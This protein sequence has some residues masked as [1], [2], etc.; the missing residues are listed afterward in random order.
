MDQEQLY[1]ELIAPL[2]LRALDGFKCTVIAYG[3]TG[4][5]KTYTMQGDESNDLKSTAAG[6]I[7]R[8]IYT[9][10][11]V[12]DE[13]Y[14]ENPAQEDYSITVSHVEVYNEDL[15]DLLAAEIVEEKQ[16][17]FGLWVACS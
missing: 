9:L 13:L 17:S 14:S 5:G 16:T 8:S 6:L 4:A 11:G 1:R 12:L 7:P 15:S 2:I 3:Q 10:F